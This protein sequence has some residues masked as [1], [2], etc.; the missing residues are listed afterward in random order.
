MKAPGPVRDLKCT[1]SEKSF[2][3][4]YCTWTEPKYP[5]GQ[6]K[7]YK[8]KLTHKNDTIHEETTYSSHI[9]LKQDLMSN[10]I[11]NVSITPVTN[12]EGK[13]A[14]TNVVFKDTGKGIIYRM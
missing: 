12:M 4:I 13:T 6:I 8:V 10:E 3:P 14:S 11:Y 2:S 7:F 1:Y 5:H 9:F